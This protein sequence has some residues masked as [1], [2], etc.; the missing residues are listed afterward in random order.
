M[1]RYSIAELLDAVNETDKETDRVELLRKYDSVPLRKLLEI[2]FDKNIKF[3]IPEGTPEYN[4]SDVYP[5]I[6][7]L[8]F[9]EVKKLYQ[10]IEGQNSHIPLQK[11]CDMWVNLL[12]FVHPK[13]AVLL[14]NIK[15]KKWPYKRITGKVIRDALQGINV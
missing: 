7:S 9:Y 5:G 4:Q 11:Q 10:F 15:D 12:Q 13:D 14:N 6:G 8:L 3:S 1:V 2:A